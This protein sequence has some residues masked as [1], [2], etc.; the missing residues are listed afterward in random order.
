MRY[1]IVALVL[2]AVA[3]LAQ[4]QPDGDD[5]PTLVVET[6]G[7]S[8]EIKH[9]LF[10]PKSKEM[11][12]VALDKTARVWDVATGTLVRTIRLPQGPGQAGE[13][14]SAALSAD[15]KLLAVGG[16]GFPK[17]KPCVFLIDVGTGRLV[18]T[19]NYPYN[20]V[21]S[22]AI[23]GKHLLAGSTEGPIVLYNLDT[24]KQVKEFPGHKGGSSHLVFAPKG[25]YFATLGVDHIGRVWSVDEGKQVAELQ[26]GKD[27]HMMRALA[28]SPDGKWIAAGLVED[29]HHGATY[30]G[31][32]HRDGKLVRQIYHADKKRVQCRALAF[33]PD[34]KG[35]VESAAHEGHILGMLW[36]VN[37]GERKHTYFDKDYTNFEDAPFE[38]AV[39]S[40]DGRFV[41]FGHDRNHRTYVYSING[42]LQRT[43]PVTYKSDKG[44][45]ITDIAWVKQT[46]TQPLQVIWRTA[47]L[48][49]E[50]R[51]L[52]PNQLK[53]TYFQHAINL[54]QLK[55]GTVPP[56]PYQLR[57]DE[58]QGVK[59]IWDKAQVK[60]QRP[61]AM[62]PA[63][64]GYGNDDD[65]IPQRTLTL[66]TPNRA[67][68]AKRD[69]I[70]VYDTETG[71]PVHASAAGNPL[72]LLGPEGWTR[73]AAVSPDDKYLVAGG[74]DHVLRIWDPKHREPL[75]SV[76]AN[77]GSWVAWTPAGYY[78]ANS[79]GERLVGWHVNN[80]FRKLASFYPVDRFRNQFCR[81]DIIA[82]VLQKG[83][84]EAAVKV[85]NVAKAK[86]GE[87]VAVADIDQLLPPKVTM[88]IDD[89]KRPVVTLRVTAESGAAGQPVTSL[90]LYMDGRLF[91]DPKT[92]GNFG[93]GHAKAQAQWN[94]TL[95]EGTHMLSVRA[96]CPDVHSFAEPEEVNGNP[97]T[98]PPTLY[99]LAVGI[100]DYDDKSL[101]LGLAKGDAEALAQQFQ[102]CCKGP[103]FG[104]VVASKLI[105]KD[106]TR[107]AILKEIKAVR[108]Q[109]KENDL[110]VFTFAG[111]GVRDKDGFFLLS[112]EADV[113]KL[114]E[115]ALSGDELRKAVAEFPCQ[116][117]LMLDACHSAGFGADQKLTKTGLRPATDDATRM[118]TDDDVG[119]AVMCA[120]MGTEKAIEKEKHGLFTQAVLEALEGGPK[121]P[122]HF[123]N[124]I[125]IH[126][127][128]SYVFD[129]V[130]FIS[131]DR[132]HP[133]LHLPWIVESFPLR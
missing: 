46:D 49:K 71:K 86:K 12:T 123:N 115:T 98:V 27:M 121:V 62:V 120:A 36:D 22:L 29:K 132:Q 9:V 48:S 25:K 74:D 122:R 23:S 70:H 6:G 8:A 32:F 113:F 130:S 41:A 108:G 18:D 80:G 128:Q 119:V 106:A 111:H 109:A 63:L 90:R 95:P 56:P 77:G 79:G 89:S 83:S 84:V 68:F 81:P 26:A 97:P 58:A 51:D 129:H 10:T 105:D 124:K 39:V 34:S 55:L 116:V 61:G 19:L 127:L 78:A 85:A 60:V 31:L 112:K 47:L 102:K 28:W 50:M 101:R 21:R 24:G 67:V 104:A 93:Q 72:P 126:H 82:M 1:V 117:L 94:F 16:R 2:V 11:I 66:V 76:Y 133:F 103:L 42:K 92:R 7:H 99:V 118:L 35:I 5:K 43:M 37:T 88:V 38:P 52:K 33:T 40:P 20:V 75:L 53:D 30:F 96:E 65:W 57:K 125:Y 131:D 114:T 107:D 100:N 59:L 4:A 64:R 44:R 87:K 45:Q 17:V 15:G 54:E 14:M 69:A 73:A 3:Q 110:F 13:L 91:P